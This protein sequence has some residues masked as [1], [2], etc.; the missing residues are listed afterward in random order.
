[1]A[2]YNMLEC[3]IIYEMQ[4]T[5]HQFNPENLLFTAAITSQ[6]VTF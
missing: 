2:D 5:S 1:M 6:I 4:I 3:E